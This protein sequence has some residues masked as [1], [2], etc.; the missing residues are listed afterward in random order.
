MGTHGGHNLLDRILQ[1]RDGHRDR[2]ARLAERRA[3]VVC[4]GAKALSRDDSHPN[5]DPQEN[6]DI[7]TDRKRKSIAQLNW[8]LAIE[9]QQHVAA[10]ERKSAKNSSRYGVPNGSPLLEP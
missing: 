4:C 2:W 5:H 10:P 3:P 1:E 9:R 6:E 8:K 7:C